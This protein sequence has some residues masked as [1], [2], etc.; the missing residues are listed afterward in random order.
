MCAFICMNPKMLNLT[1]SQPQV[2]EGEMDYG[3]LK[4]AP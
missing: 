4:D 1:L 3:F 2:G